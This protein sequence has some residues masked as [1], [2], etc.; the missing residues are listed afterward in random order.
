M[1]RIL[2][3]ATLL[4]FCFAP[5]VWAQNK[6]AVS[7]TVKDVNGQL[8]PGVT[9]IEKGTSNGAV[10]LADGSFKLSADPNGTL[11]FT[12]MG[13]AQQEVP[14]SAPSFN[15]VLKEDSKNLNE[16][17]VTALGFKRE[18]RKLGYAVTELKGSEV[19]KTNAINP[20]AALQGKVAGLDI[21]GAAG[22]PQ[23]ANRI[24]LRGAKSLNGKDQPIF[25]IDGTIFENE[26]A[27]NAVNFGNVLKNFNP[28]DF[29]SVTVLKGA[30][31]T[32]LYGTRAI[33]GAI[34]ITTKKGTTRKGLGV[35][36]SQTVQFEQVYRTPIAL[37][38]T[39][40]AGYNPFFGKDA[41]DNNVVEWAG[42][43]SF[44]PKMDGSPAKIINGDIVPFSA[45]PNNWKNTYQTGK[46]F[47]T[48]V[49][50]EGGNE[51]ANFRFSYSHVDNNSVM[52]NNGFKRDAF[53]LKSSAVIS[54]FLSAEGGVT[55]TS[56]ETTNPTRQGGDYTNENVGR[57]WIYIFPRNYDAGYWQARYMGPNPGKQDLNDYLGQYPGADY[58]F[59]LEN[60]NWLRKEK[61]LMGNLSLTG[62]ATD[63]LK[64]I[65][66][67]NFSYEQN[68]DDRRQLGWGPN[69]TGNRGLFVLSGLNRT[70]YT[71]TGMAVI[72]P[73]LGS[74]FNA[75]LNLGAETWTS[76]IGN[77]FRTAT[78]NGLRIPGLYAMTNSVGQ[79]DAKAAIEKQKRINSL[80]FAASFSYKNAWFLD[81]T[82]RNDW[83]SAL[84]YP[85][86]HGTPSYFYPSV[87]AAWEFTE[88]FKQSMP[89]W[90]T[91]GKLRASYAFVGG[92]MLPWDNNSGYVTSSVWNGAADLLPINEYYQPGTLPNMNLKPSTSS[93]VELGADVRFLKNRLGLDVAWYRSIIKDQILKIP[94]APESG[95]NERYINAGKFRNSGIEIAIN[96]RPIETKNFGWDLTLNGSKNNNKIISLYGNEKE[97]EMGNDQDVRVL[98]MVGAAYGV[99]QTN[100]GYTRYQG[101]DANDPNNG[102]P[103]ISPNS[104]DLPYKFKRGA[105]V[106]G[107]ITPDFNLGL[108]NNFNYKNWSLGFLVQA[109]IGGDMFSASHQYGT[110]RGTVASTINGRDAE[111]GG[112]AWT[113]KSGRQRNDGIIP[114]G[115]FEDGYKI[116]H[117]G[118]EVDLGGMSY[119]D[120]FD[121]GYVNP[122][123]PYEY[124][125]MVGDWGIGI[126]EAS[127]F[128]AT[129]VALREVSLG[130]T[131]PSKIAEKIR[132][133]KVRVL[134]I[135]RNLGYL[136]NN[137]PDHINPESLRNNSTSAFSEYGGTPFVRNMAVTLQLGF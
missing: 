1:R 5:A 112:I 41:D 94:A 110:G 9:V 16:V 63:W 119:R 24:V 127:V 64:F 116:T 67:G 34:L 113:D 25:V 22:G 59:A 19:A 12:F 98:A 128:D 40:G 75:S 50:V 62:T 15:I 39:Y 87:S 121:K 6:K 82:G 37:Q 84:M 35:D 56:S 45:Q 21:S 20:V 101:K 8:L 92:D 42:A 93:S 104:T 97:Y 137:L 96:A 49:A 70:Q 76:G 136:Y 71:F 13:Y 26:E 66:R 80:F 18:Q 99:I 2:L 95:V 68:A 89:S 111:H 129:Y 65:A 31:A 69:F 81:V 51:K 130:Y 60:D 17:V 14:A 100:Y 107:N 23:S 134:L 105:A 132:M 106:V 86:G 57:K 91:Y 79:V 123:S 74:D 117:N 55:F 72:T 108:N 135:G 30:A 47:N 78:T 131:M 102:K 73:K 46:Y 44:G 126:R 43:Y 52:P 29:E 120:A 109:R 122:M 90:V 133:N 85:D 54:K 36:F 125:S 115:V 27:D 4:S 114:E 58:W 28:D 10:T 61:L 124:Y 11:V 103:I 38:N 53:S 32:A 7:G 77:N 33:N 3:L 83:S 88:T 48:N 118:S